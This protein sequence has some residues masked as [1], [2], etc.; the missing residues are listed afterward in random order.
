MK[1]RFIFIMFFL[2]GVAFA[3]KYTLRFAQDS[4]L[5]N[6]HLPPTAHWHLIGLGIGAIVLQILGHMLRAYKSRYLLNPIKQARSS[7]LFRSL[8]IGYLFNTLLPLRLGEIIRAIHL[9]D[10][11]AISKTAA[12]VSI[13]I[14]RIFDGLLLSLSFIGIGFIIHTNHPEASALIIRFGVGVLSISAVLGIVVGLMRSENKLLLRSIHWFTSIF[15][16]KVRDRL[17]FIAWSGIYG[18]RL[19]WSEQTHR[20]RYTALT[21]GMWL[22]YFA[23]TACVVFAFFSGYSFSEVLYIIQST[24]VGVSAP[25]GPGYVGTFHLIVAKLLNPL[26]ISNV[27]SFSLFVWLIIIAPISLIGLYVL[28]AQR[29]TT[30][31]NTSTRES[32]INKLR[33]DEDISSELSHFLDAYLQGEEINQILTHAELDNKF[34][35][36]KSFKGGSNAHTMLVWQN[37]ELFVKKITLAQYAEKLAAQATWLKERAHLPH[38][39]RIIREEQTPTYYYFD[40]NYLEAYT[41]F[42]EFI[43]SHNGKHNDDVLEKVLVFMRGS[44][45]TNA[46]PSVNSKDLRLYIDSKVLGKVQDAATMHSELNSLLEA[47]RLTVNGKS[48]LNLPY[49]VEKIKKHTRAMNDLATYHECAIHGDLTVDNL[50]VSPEGDFLV[51]DPNNENQVSTPAVDYGKLYQSLHSG[52]EFLIQLEHCRVHDTNIYFE[53]VKSQKYAELFHFL[54]AKLKKDLDKTQYRSILF[55]EAVHYCRM[56]TYRA[57]INP[58][59]LVVFYAVATKLFNEYLEQYE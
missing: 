39:P 50:I 34:N 17:R 19:M 12:L 36:I 53:E 29:R 55:H 43:H 10:S 54:D 18:A 48:Y 21:V 8:S 51:L 24:Y 40:I 16:S 7:D 9:G 14:E 3:I 31:R 52:Y 27:V 38:L 28:L 37:S 49:I 41:P 59:T 30:K 1:K 2:I 13:I 23:S 11:L 47:K 58:D 22:L 6:V 46:K 35:V 57:S 5:S 4:N 44:I 20:M 33:R 56:L 26:H 32:L 15:N 42:F 25:A 45:Y